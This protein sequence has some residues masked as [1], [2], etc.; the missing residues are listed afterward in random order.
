MRE[1]VRDF[2]MD[3]RLS[4]ECADDVSILPRGGVGLERRGEGGR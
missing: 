4:N 3:A 1:A 2:R